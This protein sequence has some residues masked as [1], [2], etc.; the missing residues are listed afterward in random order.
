MLSIGSSTDDR[1]LSVRSVQMIGCC[2]LGPAQ[3]GS[4]GS[5]EECGSGSTGFEL[6]TVLKLN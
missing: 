5:P 1:V 4:E 2:L 6:S 3:R